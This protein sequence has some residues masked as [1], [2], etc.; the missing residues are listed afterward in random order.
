MGDTAAPHRVP[1]SGRV[2]NDIVSPFALKGS[3]SQAGG[4]LATN[5]RG[6]GGPGACPCEA[7]GSACSGETAGSARSRCFARLREYTSL[8]SSVIWLHGDREC[9]FVQGELVRAVSSRETEW[10]TETPKET[11]YSSQ[12]LRFLHEGKNYPASN[13]CCVCMRRKGQYLPQRG[14]GKGQCCPAVVQQF[15]S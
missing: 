10:H 2:G 12:A 8:F 9:L 13:L 4:F 5:A 14:W 1:S 15:R 3:A 7:V 11:K 6:R